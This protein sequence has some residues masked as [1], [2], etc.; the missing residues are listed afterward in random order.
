[1]SR[2]EPGTP[3]KHHDRLNQFLRSSAATWNISLP[4]P[5][6][7]WSPAK[8]GKTQQ[9][10]CVDSLKVL[11]W[12]QTKLSVSPLQWRESTIDPALRLVQNSDDKLALLLLLLKN[13]RLRAS[14]PKSQGSGE[15]QMKTVPQSAGWT[16]L[17]VD[18]H[19]QPWEAE[20]P[21]TLSQIDFTCTYS[22]PFY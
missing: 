9:Q 6:L 1:M 16:N 15:H 12:Q 21:I 11:Y 2:E 8:S 18:N 13:E 22:L 17:V 4:I 20:D 7:D 3:G 14:P 10:L 19:S 5:G